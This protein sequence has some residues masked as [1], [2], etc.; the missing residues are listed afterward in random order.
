MEV[1]LHYYNN[2]YSIIDYYNHKLFH[3]Y[4]IIMND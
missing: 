3:Y 4:S 1:V 2:Q